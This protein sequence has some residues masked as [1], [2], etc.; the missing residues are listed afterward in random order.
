[1]GQYWP[2]PSLSYWTRYVKTGR[3]N[4]FR[5]Q[6]DLR[7]KKTPL[8]TRRLAPRSVNRP[9]R[10]DGH[11]NGYTAME[12]A[13]MVP[14]G[15]VCLGSSERQNLPYWWIHLDVNSKD[16][17]YL[18]REKIVED[19]RNK[20]F[21][22]DVSRCGEGPWCDFPS[23]RLKS[24]QANLD[25]IVQG[26]ALQPFSWKYERDDE[27]QPSW[28]YMPLKKSCC[29]RFLLWTVP[30]TEEIYPWI[31]KTL[32]LL[33]KTRQSCRQGILAIILQQ[34]WQ[35]HAESNMQEGGLTKRATTCTNPFT[36]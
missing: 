29:R 27:S 14:Q 5:R 1:M 20:M 13:E 3:I 12:Q 2:S 25:H 31:L 16:R 18:V 8:C 17:T 36:M 28:Y 21:D 24:R 26:A 32:Q 33:S 11:V 4:L 34:I 10:S 22:L 19:Q 23:T 30:F 6:D 7:I 9:A 15:G 35:H